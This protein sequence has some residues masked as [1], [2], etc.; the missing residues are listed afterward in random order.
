[1]W[2][3]YSFAAEECSLP[4]A[5]PRGAVPLAVRAEPLTAGRCCFPSLPQYFHKTVGQLLPLAY[6]LLQRSLFAEIIQS[7]LANRRE[8]PLDQLAP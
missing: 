7:H 2:S 3:E 1:M 8:E 6:T 4:Q 5:Q